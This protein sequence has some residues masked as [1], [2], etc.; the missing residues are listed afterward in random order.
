MG[1]ALR[2]LLSVG[3][4]VGTTTTQV[5]FSR[6]VLQDVARP[7]QVPRIQVEAKSILYKSPIYFTP[8]TSPD[9]VNAEALKAI[10]RQEY[11]SA[12]IAPSQVETGAVI[13]T[14]EIART[15]NADAILQAI[16]DLAGDFVVTVAGP[17]VESIIAG[18]G[19][20]AASY[21]S[22]HFAQVTH[23]DIGGGTANAV[24]FRSGEF[25]SASAMAVGGRQLVIERT[26]GI[27]RH[28]PP[29]GKKIIE[30]LNLPIQVG[31]Q[32]DMQVLE[33]F[34]ACM[35]DLVADLA[36]G[37]ESSLSSAFYLSAPLKHAN[38]SRVLMFSG[39][40]GTYFFH[41]VPINTLSDVLIH[42]DVGPLLASALRVNP[43]IQHFKLVEPEETLRATVMGAACQT[44][45]LSGSTIWAETELLPL[46]NLP[47]VRPRI[48][49]LQSSIDISEACFLAAQRWETSD[50][51]GQI[52]MVIDFPEKIDY[53]ALQVLASGIL[54]YAR[55]RKDASAPI[56][57]ILE[58]DYAQVL[59]QSIKAMSP[60]LPVV[61]IDQVGLDEG[62]FIDL[63][64][65]ILGGRVVPLSVKTLIFYN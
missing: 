11:R 7:G 2:Q 15:Q 3:I 58:H 30:A 37:V 28:I 1:Q 25:L 22:V 49:N 47:V 40:V 31:R 63:G 46:R 6:L 48:A 54:Q 60:G 17:N 38:Q 61:A 33:A 65:P 42:D 64:M 57:L 56:V 35:A 62:D 27:V 39:G 13:V 51:Q 19:S 41:P 5:V 14:G 24:I 29:P 34:C 45:T 52:A 12:G 20:G 21:S 50:D 4:D 59:G 55:A 36:M 53:P 32:V 43:R 26:S 18:K 23:I 10:I 16:S 9:E 8:L 44:I